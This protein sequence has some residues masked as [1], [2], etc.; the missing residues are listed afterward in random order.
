MSV[1]PLDESIRTQFASTWEQAMTGISAVHPTVDLLPGVMVAGVMRDLVPTYPS[2]LVVAGSTGP[3]SEFSWAI[4]LDAAAAAGAGDVA[5]ALAAPAGDAPEAADNAMLAV[6]SFAADLAQM[7][8]ATIGG[9]A[10]W[11]TTPGWQGL[12]ERGH[13][14]DVPE[15]QMAPAP[16]LERLLSPG[17]RVLSADVAVTAGDMPG[18]SLHF[19]FEPAM[20]GQLYP[21]TATQPAHEPAA[22]QADQI[23][24][25][26]SAADAPTMTQTVIGAAAA[27]A[28]GEAGLRVIHGDKAQEVDRRDQVIAA[29]VPRV[30]AR[31]AAFEPVTDRPARRTPEE[32]QAGI[33]L[34]MDVPLQISVELGRTRRKVR[35]VMAL[36]PGSVVELDRLAGEPVDVLVNGKLLGKGEVVVINENFAIR[37]TDIVS[38]AERVQELA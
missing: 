5:A 38:P 19:L 27:A 35:E 33:G 28:Q 4:L 37:I 23:D 6:A 15:G 31:R 9:D 32:L 13:F 17:A 30:T 3:R 16:G 36:A 18:P 22:G 34:L 14:I 12:L 25:V 29:P 1:L 2:I 26:Q 7:L 11:Q 21:S 10:A 24:E 8:F 20:V